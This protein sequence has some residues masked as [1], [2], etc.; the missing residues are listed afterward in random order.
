MEGRWPGAVTLRRGTSRAESR[1][2]NA[3]VAFARLSMERGG[4]AF[5]GDCADALAD[6]GAE[7]VLS[8]PLSRASQ[9]LWRQA[10]FVQHA[11]LRVFRRELDDVLQPDHA[12][13]V[14]GRDDIPAALAVDAAAFDAFW[15]FDRAAFLEAVEATPRAVIHVVRR[16]DGLAGYA[17]TGMG[18]AIAFLQRIAVHPDHQGLGLGRSLVRA[19]AIWSHCA[20]A[21]ALV[22]NSQYENDAAH[23]LYR[24]EGFRDVASGLA[25]L[26]K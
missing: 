19:A 1:P 2:W 4:P 20:G 14:G 25:V 13:D 11:R 24:S 21:S 26:R 7:A 17:I 10:D 3:D 5:L 22:L 18:S 6:L 8:P 15:R 23:A 9:H 16:G 12:V